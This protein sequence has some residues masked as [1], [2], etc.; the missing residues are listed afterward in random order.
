MHL[1]G[2]TALIT[3]GTSGIGAGG[4][5]PVAAARRCA[6]DRFQTTFKLC[7]KLSAERP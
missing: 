7:G 1:T 5:G 6:Y 2:A 4:H 3:G